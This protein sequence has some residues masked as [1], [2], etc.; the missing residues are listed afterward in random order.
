M[1]S[2]VFVLKSELEFENDQFLEMQAI[3]DELFFQI[4]Y[5]GLVVV[6]LA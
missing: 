1:R 4:L 6:I 2:R 5:L 3:F